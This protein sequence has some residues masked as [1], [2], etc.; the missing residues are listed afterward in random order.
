MHK[1]R[2]HLFLA[3]ILTFFAGAFF[4]ASPVQAAVC[5]I[6]TNTLINQAYVDSNSC[7]S[8]EINANVAST[9][10]SGTVDLQGSGTVTV[11]SGYTMTMGSS[12]AMILGADDDFVVEANATATHLLEDVYGLRISARNITISGT[13]S[14]SE[15]GCRRSGQYGDDGY[16]VNVSTGV[17]GY[18]AGGYGR[19]GGGSGAGGGGGSHAGIGG[20]GGTAFAGGSILYGDAIFPSTLGSGGGTGYYATAYGGAGGGII[21]VTSTGVLTVNGTIRANGGNGNPT[22]FGYNGGG[23]GAGGSVSVSAATLAGS[24]TISANGGTGGAPGGGGGSGGRVA[25]R[26]DALTTFALS[27][28]TATKGSAGSGGVAGGTGTTYALDRVTDDGVG[29][30]TITSGFNFPSQGDYTRTSVNISSGAALSC[31]EAHSLN[32]SAVNWLTLTDLTWNC[33]A[34]NTSISIA[35][36]AGISTTNTTLTF[37][38]ASSVAITAPSWTNVTTT[39]NVT[40]PGASS[41]W[42]IASDLTLRSMTYTGGMRQ[43]TVLKVVGC[44]LRTPSVF[45][46]S[47][48]R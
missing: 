18:Q 32:V 13:L 12:S 25:V 6:T 1:N 15:R 9:T 30:L 26:Y 44:R 21:Q 3:I 33:S 39:I 22:D 47:V 36:S 10:W 19:G 42:D 5:S 2:A 31:V 43:Q 41:T 20:G 14:G 8:I 48:P 37:S 27:S 35:S 11:K 7:D 38:A 17:C 45:R 16:G 46:L 24:G 28:I 40:Q 23:G 29:T 4:A 34:T